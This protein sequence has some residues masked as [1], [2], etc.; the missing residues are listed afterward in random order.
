MSVRIRNLFGRR[1]VAD[2]KAAHAKAVEVLDELYDLIEEHC[3]FSTHIDT[4]LLRTLKIDC[5]DLDLANH[6]PYLNSFLP[7]FFEPLPLARL[8]PLDLRNAQTR[9]KYELQKKILS[10]PSRYERTPRD[11][12]Q[13]LSTKIMW[14]FSTFPREVP[15]NRSP[16]LRR[17]SGWLSTDFSPSIIDDEFDDLVFESREWYPSDAFTTRTGFST[18]VMFTV[19]LGYEPDERLLRAEL[20][21]I[22]AAMITRLADSEYEDHSV[23]PVMVI[24]LLGQRKVRILQAHNN[25]GGIVIR[26]SRFIRFNSPEEATDN[27]DLLMRFM[28]SSTVGDTADPKNFLGMFT[29]KQ[30]ETPPSTPGPSGVGASQEQLPEGTPENMSRLSLT[31]ARQGSVRVRNFLRSI[32]SRS[33]VISGGRNIFERPRREDPPTITSLLSESDPER[34]LF[35]RSDEQEV[36]STSAPKQEGGHP[37]T[38]SDEHELQRGPVSRNLNPQ[39]PEEPSYIEFP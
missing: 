2:R 32:R 1:G 9:E 11:S 13:S 26:M 37:I 20:I 19:I 30:P 28:A 35:T 22:V 12:A 14:S 31:M 5:R 3:S 7:V 34:R 27:M 23:V 17:L 36:P 38:R 8:P 16:S 29:K 25:H 6:S 21:S 18:H 24:S 15:G 4:E 39:T 10:G 33:R